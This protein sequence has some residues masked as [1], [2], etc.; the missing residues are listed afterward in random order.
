MVMEAL[1]IMFNEL[2]AAKSKKEID[3][4]GRKMDIA[5]K[6]AETRKKVDFLALDMDAKFSDDIFKYAPKETWDDLTKIYFNRN[7]IGS[8]GYPNSKIRNFLIEE[9][10][11]IIDFVNQKESNSEIAKA[12]IEYYDEFRF[13]KQ[14]KKDN[15]HKEVQNMENTNEVKLAKFELLIEKTSMWLLSK[16]N[17]VLFYMP[18]ALPLKG[19]ENQYRNNPYAAV[20]FNKVFKYPTCKFETG[21]NYSK[22]LLECIRKLEDEH[23]ECYWQIAKELSFDV[24]EDELMIEDVYSDRVSFSLIFWALLLAALDDDFYK[25]E[26]SVI[27]DMACMFDFNEDMM[28]DWTAA[29]KYLLDC[30]QFSEN[31]AIE[32]KTAEAN[33]FFKHIN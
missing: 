2:G 16:Y 9:R 5:M 8:I 32:F 13:Q 29:V 17:D 18:V 20:V 31:M 21:K 26:I 24:D 7:L 15:S 23:I 19:K 10:K 30:N 27:S 11:R 28:D 25:N 33:L 14:F 4:V 1:N 3:E 12:A 6:N 22:S